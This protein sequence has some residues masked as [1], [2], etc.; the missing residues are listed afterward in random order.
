MATEEPSGSA[1][2]AKL[3][4]ERQKKLLGADK[5]RSK[6]AKRKSDER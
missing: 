4:R 5:F 3:Y 2:R 1:V 6:E